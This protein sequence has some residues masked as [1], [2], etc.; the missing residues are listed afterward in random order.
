M[1]F[2][3]SVFFRRCVKIDGFNQEEESYDWPVSQYP[4]RKEI[5][6]QLAPFLRLYET[7]SEFHTQHQQWVHGALSGVNPDKVLPAL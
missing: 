6:E 5:Q 2:F 4:E 7:A 3:V 1:Y